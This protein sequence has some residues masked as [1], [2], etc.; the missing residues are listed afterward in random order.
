MEKEVIETRTARVW[1]GGD[2][3]IRVVSLPFT[4]MT[5]ESIREVNVH[6]KTLCKGKKY[7]IFTDIRG[8]K[9]I[10]REARLFVSSEDSVNVCSA[11]ALLIG[12]PVS[13]VI[14]NLFLGLN[15]PPYPT[16]L[17]SNEDEAVEW[18]K[19]F[20]EKEES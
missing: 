9:S 4:N 7:P 1:L 15:K 8:V 19:G 6:L 20:I 17:F 18:L 16:K 3:I 10:T 2:G 11:A 12:S 5:L 13:K 14:G